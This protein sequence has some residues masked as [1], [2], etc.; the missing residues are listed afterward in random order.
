VTDFRPG[1]FVAVRC[2]D[3]K[4]FHYGMV[5]RADVICV[6]SNVEYCLVKLGPPHI[7]VYVPQNER[8]VFVSTKGF[9]EMLWAANREFFCV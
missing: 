9:T 7:P 1:D 3:G 6:G 8:L 2:A 5:L 4:T